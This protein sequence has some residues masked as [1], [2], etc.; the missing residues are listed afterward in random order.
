MEQSPIQKNKKKNVVKQLKLSE[1]VSNKN[2]VDLANYIY[3]LSQRKERIH[4]S[5]PPREG[6]LLT[7]SIAFSATLT[8][9]SGWVL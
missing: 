8:E 2:K 1:N 4:L 5:F 9:S 7:L 6:G 3:S